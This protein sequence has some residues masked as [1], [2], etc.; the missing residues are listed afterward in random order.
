M[1]DMGPLNIVLLTIDCWRGDHLGANGATPSPTPHLDRL[2]AQGTLFEQAITC[3]GWTRPAMMALFSSVYASRHHGGSLRRLSALLPVVS[4]LL[5]S[6]GYETTGLTSNPV[7]GRNAGFERGFDT[8]TDLESGDARFSKRL[9]KVRRIRGSRYPLRLLYQPLTHRLLRL[10][11][12]RFI[13]PEVTASAHEVSDAAL[14]WL[15]GSPKRTWFL[16]AHYM[17]IHWAYRAS[18]RPHTPDEITQSWWDRFLMLRIIRERWALNPGPERVARWRALYREGLTTL[19]EQIGRL[20]DHLRATGRW[21]NTAVIVTSDHGEEFYEHGRVGHSY[22]G[23]YNEGVHVPLIVRIPGIPGRHRVRQLV[24]TLDVA[25]TLL[26]LA[27]VPP[28]ETMLGTSLLPLIKGT[29]FTTHPDLN[30]RPAVTEMLGHRNSYRYRV[31][32][33]TDTYTYIHDIDQPHEN[34]WYDRLDDSGEYDDEYHKGNPTARHFDQLR[35][36]HVAPI[37]LDLLE[38]EHDAD[39]LGRAHRP[40][41]RP[42]RQRAACGNFAATGADGLAQILRRVRTAVTPPCSRSSQVPI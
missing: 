11:G 30:Q 22:N 35:F 19:D 38:I 31:S 17:D 34:E 9:Q 3:G 39:A 16:W 28:A 23:L 41:H 10:L 36:E 37:V 7:C 27:G 20:V 42:G 24:S 1:N 18:R 33:R 29:E 15:A 14:A 2:A 8:F 40:V 5:Q 4:E 12:V 21:E 13:P 32:V 6:Q 26:E 25:P